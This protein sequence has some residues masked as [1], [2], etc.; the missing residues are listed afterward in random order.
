[1]DVKESWDLHFMIVATCGILAGTQRVS[2]IA[3]G[4]ERSALAPL[5]RPRVLRPRR[6]Q[7]PLL[8]S[9]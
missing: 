3:Y 7:R 9:G 8:N 1:M 5:F 6:I 2:E 4:P